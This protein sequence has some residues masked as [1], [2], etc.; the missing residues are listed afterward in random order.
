MKKLTKLSLIFAGLFSIISTNE[1]LAVLKYEPVKVVDDL[2]TDHGYPSPAR[3][4][5]AFEARRTPE[6]GKQTRYCAYSAFS[7][8]QNQ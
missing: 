5:A 7:Y 8:G 3:V 1:T 4:D 6:N 2:M